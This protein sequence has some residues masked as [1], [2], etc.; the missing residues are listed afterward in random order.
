M[1]SEYKVLNNRLNTRLKAEARRR[2]GRSDKVK[3][4]GL[5]TT[6]NEGEMYATVLKL[7]G[8]GMCNVKC[9]DG[10]IRICIIRKKFR[11]RSKRE[12]QVS[13][14]TMVMVGLRTWE[15]PDKNGREKC[16]LLEVYSSSD[17]RKLKQK[18]S[19]NFENIDIDSIYENNNYDFEFDTNEYNDNDDSSEN[20]NSNSDSMIQPNRY[21]V[22]IS[23][24][25]DDDEIYEYDENC[26]IINNSNNNN[27]NYT[28][29]NEQDDNI[30]IDDI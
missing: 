15:K 25:E 11:G 21:D 13:S 4:I 7:F 29:S 2:T 10:K 3:I 1:D 28:N 14:G 24:D 20:S 22:P 16:D 9:I 17:V 8:N 30:N 12:N 19:E 27:N 5:R 6:E 18:S 26:Y 23:D